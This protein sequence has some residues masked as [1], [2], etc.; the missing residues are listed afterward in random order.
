M[1]FSGTDEY[2]I[3][4][5]CLRPAVGLLV[6]TELPNRC[7]PNAGSIF[8]RHAGV[9]I[10]AI[11]RL[12]T[13]LHGVNRRSIRWS[14]HLLRYVYFILQWHG[15]AGANNLA[16]YTGTAADT[17]HPSADSGLWSNFTTA[18]PG[19]SHPTVPSR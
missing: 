13:V 5:W 6:S 2:A 9:H 12:P 7:C 17:N 19:I 3:S 11:C 14:L 15:D 10:R 4:L 16:R 8:T 1:H 18:W